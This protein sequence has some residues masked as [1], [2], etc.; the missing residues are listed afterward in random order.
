VEG[1]SNA[2]SRS[3]RPPHFSFKRVPRHQPSLCSVFVC[4]YVSLVTQGTQILPQAADFPS[5]SGFLGPKQ[6]GERNLRKLMCV[7]TLETKSGGRACGGIFFSL[8]AAFVRNHCTFFLGMPIPKKKRAV[9]S[10][11]PVVRL[12]AS[13]LKPCKSR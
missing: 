11:L 10:I 7:R 13:K 6:T 3:L 2:S 4:V 8:C 5:A 9:W 12:L 1:A